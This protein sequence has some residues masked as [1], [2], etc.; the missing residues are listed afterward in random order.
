[1]TSPGLTDIVV[2]SMRGTGEPYQN[3]RGVYGAQP[4][5]N[6]GNMMDDVVRA[7]YAE[8]VAHIP[9]DYYASI[10]PA[11]GMKMFH[12]TYHDG[13][14]K[15]SLAD[16]EGV[17]TIWIGYSLGALILGDLLAAGELANCIGMILFADP[18]RH[19]VQIDNTGVDRAFYGAAGARW[20]PN[21]TQPV[22]SFSAP[23]DPISA[24]SAGNGFRLLAQIV[25]GAPQPWNVG[26]LDMA[27]TIAAC[28]RY[29]GTPSIAGA[30]AKI[31]RHVCYGV[32][33]MPGST[34]TYTKAGAAAAATIIR[35]HREIA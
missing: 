1:M 10:A 32:E 15:A 19:R 34:M 16:A 9:V 14:R 29:L 23:D 3:V 30:H 8:G 24:L 2:R 21:L 20:I 11:G 22:Y 12:E 17:P 33:R 18:L 25:T 26:Y 4:G 35:K 31:S 6:Q 7:A 28:Q 27:A 5:N 13:W